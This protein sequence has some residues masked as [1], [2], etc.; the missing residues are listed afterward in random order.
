[1]LVWLVARRLGVELLVPQGD[2][3]AA[4]EI[5]L[6]AVVVTSAG[7]ALAG[8]ALLAALE[9]A[10]SLWVAIAVAVVLTS[11]VPLFTL[12]VGGATVAALTLMHLAVGVVFIPLLARTSG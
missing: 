12:G 6:R 7:A 3:A 1:M 9:R 4:D 2:G 10:T 8:W 5:G 11:L